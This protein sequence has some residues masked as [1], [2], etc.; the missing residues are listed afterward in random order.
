MYC[1]KMWW[2]SSVN[3]NFLYNLDNFNPGAW[4]TDFTHGS[5]NHKID[6]CKNW[7]AWKNNDPIGTMTTTLVGKGKGMLKFGNCWKTGVVKVYL[8]G[9][10]IE[11][12]GPGEFKE[13]LFEYN[14]GSKLEI[15]EFDTAIIQIDNFVLGK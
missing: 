7:Y 2:I 15:G 1:E 11:T 9:S 4:D 10:R 3:T 8:D 12:A 13:V 14:D 6:T 5:W